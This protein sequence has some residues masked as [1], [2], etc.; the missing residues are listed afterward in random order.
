MAFTG[1][2][3][4][5]LEKIVRVFFRPFKFIHLPVHRFRQNQAAL[6]K[7]QAHDLT[8][9]EMPDKDREAPTTESTRRH[10][11]FLPSVPDARLIWCY[12]EYREYITRNIILFL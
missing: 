2:W 7:F 1:R 8:T 6:S 4:S 11:S 3:A 9:V 5:D 10:T 12:L